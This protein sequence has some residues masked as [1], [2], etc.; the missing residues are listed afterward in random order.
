MLERDLPAP[1]VCS[2][3]TRDLGQELF[4]PPNVKGWDGGVSWITTNSLL[5]RYNQAG[6]LIYGDPAFLRGS[7]ATDRPLMDRLARAGGGG[8]DVER[9][10]TREERGN[11]EKLI[12]ALERRLL[13]SKLN[14]E[15]DRALRE[16][17]DA[18]GELDTEDIRGA[19]RLIMATPEFQL[20]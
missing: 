6:L 5:A 13:Q 16:Y 9:L 17:L 15:Q 2:R 4:A 19:I 1:R 10:L 12:A 3:L 20:T 18:R 7:A 11:T 14:P 8:V